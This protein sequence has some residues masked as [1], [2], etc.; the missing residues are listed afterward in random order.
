VRKERRE[1]ILDGYTLPCILSVLLEIRL[2]VFINSKLISSH[3]IC[4]VTRADIGG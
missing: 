1:K 4:L 2:L 3:L